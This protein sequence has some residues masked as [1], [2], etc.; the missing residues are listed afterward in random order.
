MFVNS[1]RMIAAALALLST[2]LATALAADPSVPG[3]AIT[4]T[5]VK[6]AIDR[7][8]Q[9]YADKL[10]ADKDKQNAAAIAGKS[11]QLLRDPQTPVSGD[12]DSDIAVVEF[13]DYQCP[14]CKATEPR[15]EKLLQEDRHWK[16]IIKEF[17]I[18]GPESLVASKAALASVKQGKYEAFHQAMMLHKGRLQMDDIW[19]M[20]ASVGCDVDQL[21]KDMDKPEIADQLLANFNLARALR[22]KETPSFIVD[23]RFLNSTSADIDFPK[24]IA[25]ARAAR[26]T[27]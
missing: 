9:D 21:R 27:H 24:E 19:A 7:A 10:Q 15:L 22:I 5:A 25:L 23:T 20:A 3:S 18:L 6:A 1:C 13:F 2:P 14:Y 12:R 8:V 17:P 26:E 11:A 4:D 16:L